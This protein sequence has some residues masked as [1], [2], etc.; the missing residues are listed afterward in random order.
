MSST[1]TWTDDE[2]G[3]IADHMTTPANVLARKL[4]RSP[5]AIYKA[6]ARVK[7]GWVRTRETW[8]PAE[9]E[10][11]LSKSGT[12]TSA[13]IAHLL[14]GRTPESIK[15]RRRTLR[16]PHCPPAAFYNP[17]NV[18][19]RRLLAKT[20]PSCG[21]LLP[22]EKFY[23]RKTGNRVAAIIETCAYCTSEKS[24]KWRGENPEEQP[25]PKGEAMK[26]Y[27]TMAQELSLRSATRQGEPYLEADF[28]VLADPHMSQLAKALK[29]RRTYYAVSNACAK[30]AFTSSSGIAHGD[31]LDAAWHIDNPNADR[32]EEITAA[33]KQEFTDAGIQFPEWDWDDEDLKET[34]T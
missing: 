11:V 2:M 3:V 15:H 7:R 8:S 4:G 5:D 9:D 23:R 27:V 10:I 33:L 6:R 26:R 12:L 29:L 19:T 31:R 1:A 20:C 14:P 17:R 16:V 34:A 21:E 32:V 30:N 18:G 13:Q 22:G 24:K 28:K 25:R